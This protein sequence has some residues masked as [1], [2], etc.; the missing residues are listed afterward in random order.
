MGIYISLNPRTFANPRSQVKGRIAFG[1]HALKNLE[2]AFFPS[3][4]SIW[5]NSSFTI[6]DES[7]EIVPRIELPSPV[8][9]MDLWEKLEH[10]TKESTL[11]DQISSIIRIEGRWDL[12]SK[13][14]VGY[15][16]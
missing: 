16:S 12:R 3:A 13:E 4:L 10:F 2:S 5:R 7:L 1:M 11:E 15:V 8:S 6:K 9:Y 14:L